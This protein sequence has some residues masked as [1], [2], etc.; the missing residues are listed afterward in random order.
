VVAR[1]ALQQ[2]TI[3]LPSG[4]SHLVELGSHRDSTHAAVTGTPA[5]FWSA[6]Q[7]T[8]AQAGAVQAGYLATY[9]DG[10]VS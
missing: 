7:L 3:Q 6:T 2:F 5:S 8:A 10:Q 4:A 1:Y 9:P